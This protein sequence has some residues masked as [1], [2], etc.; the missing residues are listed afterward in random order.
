MPQLDGCLGP[1]WGSPKDAI[2]RVPRLAPSPF[3][4]WLFCL[5]SLFSILSFPILP[6]FLCL[7]GSLPGVPAQGNHQSIGCSYRQ[8]SFVEE[9]DQMTSLPTVLGEQEGSRAWEGLGEE[10]WEY[11]PSGVL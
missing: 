7:P 11:D 9:G 6:L 1:L 5:S 10:F 2:P 8:C 3:P 4:S